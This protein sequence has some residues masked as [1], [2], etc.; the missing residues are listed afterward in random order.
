MS[1]SVAEERCALAPA[2]PCCVSGGWNKAWA[3]QLGRIIPAPWMLSTNTGHQEHKNRLPRPTGRSPLKERSH[4][5]AYLEALLHQLSS[6]SAPSALPQQGQRFCPS[7]PSTTASFG[8][9]CAMP[10]QLK[11]VA[12]IRDR[13][14]RCFCST[15]VAAAAS[16]C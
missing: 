10:H 4:F 16:V 2:A 9:T 13:C 12:A 7:S 15:A 11:T 6:R 1:L 5:T 14:R 8:L 3:L